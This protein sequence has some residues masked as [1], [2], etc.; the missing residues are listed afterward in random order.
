MSAAV[1][2]T[3]TILTERDVELLLDLY[4]YRYLSVGQVRRLHF[5]STQTAYRR[6]RALLSL[7]YVKSFVAPHVTERIFH[8]DT[9]G[10]KTVADRLGVDTSELKWMNG[11]RP[12][13]DYYF[14]RH[15]LKS[16]DFRI[17]LTEACREQSDNN[18]RLLG[19]IPEY[20]GE[21][22]AVT[23]GR[24]VTKYVKDFVCDINRPSEKF[25]H[26]PDAVFA[27]GKNNTPALFFLEID[28]GTETISN[29]EKGVLKCIR[30]YL[31][32]LVSGGYRRYE[33]DFGSTTPFKGFRAL[34]VTT[35]QVRVENIRRAAGVLPFD[36]KAKRFV[37]LT[38]EAQV[39]GQASDAVDGSDTGSTS[40]GSNSTNIFQ[41]VWRSADADD[42]HQYRIG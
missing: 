7:G 19:F 41:P 30:F 24:S 31:N 16:T 42:E 3:K 36:A 11:S 27:L 34:I 14:L 23:D 18:L 8:L 28:R 4:K 33:T 40:R 6:L 9:L 21:R 39:Y 12:P 1:E 20:Y 38:D 32:Y 2:K 13:K 17:A 10:A 29:S 35:S 37:W 5:P 15:F 22:D 25:S 26:A